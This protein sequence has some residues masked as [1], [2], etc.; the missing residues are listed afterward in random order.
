MTLTVVKLFPHIK[1]VV[2]KYKQK[3]PRDDLKKFA[4]QVRWSHLNYRI[5]PLISSLE[6]GQ[7]TCRIRL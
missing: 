6:G 1:Y 2:D 3:L 5:T 4:K 7:E